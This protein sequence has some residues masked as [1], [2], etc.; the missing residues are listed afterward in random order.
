MTWSYN[1]CMHTY[2]TFLLLILFDK[3]KSDWKNHSNTSNRV[4]LFIC[5]GSHTKAIL[6][7]AIYHLWTKQIHLYRLILEQC[8]IPY[9]IYCFTAWWYSNRRYCFSVRA[10]YIHT[11]FHTI[12]KMHGL[13]LI[14]TDKPDVTTGIGKNSHSIKIESPSTFNR[15]FH[16]TESNGVKWQKLSKYG[17]TLKRSYFVDFSFRD[18]VIRRK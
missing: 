18:T 3:L 9:V 16:S 13:S 15:Y 11:R 1:L 14:E 7:V 6:P 10:R 4:I 8:D 17:R 5:A 2:S 12:I